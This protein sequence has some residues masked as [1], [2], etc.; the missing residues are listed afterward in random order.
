M[1]TWE[2]AS[3]SPENRTFEAVA[4]SRAFRF[5]DDVVVAVS[6]APDG[7]ARVDVRS[8]SRE[9]RGDFGINARRIVQYLSLLQ[10]GGKPILQ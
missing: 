3:T 7:H 4:T 5:Q 9:P 8:K 2:V 1:K 6:A 10:K